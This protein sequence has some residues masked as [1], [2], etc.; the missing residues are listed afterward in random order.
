MSLDKQSG[1][2]ERSNAAFDKWYVA[3]SHQLTNEQLCRL[4]WNRGW[5]AA[6]QAHPS[7]TADPNAMQDDANRYRKLLAASEMAFPALSVCVDPENDAEHKYGRKH[8]DQIIDSYD[9]IQPIQRES[10]PADMPASDA[11]KAPIE[12]ISNLLF[13]L[14][15]RDKK[16][17]IRQFD[18]FVDAAKDYL[19][20]PIVATVPSEPVAWQ[21]R[22]KTIEG[23]S[24]WYDA[25][26]PTSM[27]KG[28][29]LCEVLGG[30]EY[31]WRPLYAAPGPTEQAS[32]VPNDAL[33]VQVI[34]DEA[35]KYFGFSQAKIKDD[36]TIVTAGVGSL[37]EFSHAIRGIK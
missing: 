12:I 22:Q 30:I 32:D 1:A 18:E 6:L 33:D 37:I 34:L 28:P 27:G 25:K 36:G 14:T 16:N 17:R 3:Q 10:T 9:L 8:I 29:A 19:A 11:A 2:D 13:A 4:I 31:Q 26:S 24:S 5:Q 15:E 23:W 35:K 20:A 21:E 7:A